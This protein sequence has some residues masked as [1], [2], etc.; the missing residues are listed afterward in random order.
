MRHRITRILEIAKHCL[1]SGFHVVCDKPMTVSVNQAQELA[2]L[3]EETGLSFGLT[4]NYTGYPMVRHARRM[5][6]DG[7]LGEIRRVSCEYLQGWLAKDLSENKQAVWRT[8]PNWLT[9]RLFWRYR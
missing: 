8:D 1:N 9:V 4:Y 3:V 5:V 6:L 2:E 7:Q